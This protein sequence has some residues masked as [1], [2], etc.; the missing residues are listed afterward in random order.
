[1]FKIKI[2]NDKANLKRDSKVKKIIL[3]ILSILF[4][5]NASSKGTVLSSDS[6]KATI[7]RSSIYF[8][9]GGSGGIYSLN[10][11]AIFFIKQRFKASVRVGFSVYPE[12]FLWGYPEAVF[13]VM[14]QALYGEKNH[15]ELG[16]GLSIT[17]DKDRLNDDK[18]EISNVGYYSLGYRFQKPNGGF[19][20]GII[21]GMIPFYKPF[22][23]EPRLG[24]S[25]G[26]TIKTKQNKSYR[27]DVYDK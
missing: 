20:F 1:M 4:F 10:Y 24:V 3:L 13:P 11:D 16:A 27:D 12:K 23:I 18:T 7:C 21:F 5:I 25:L 19:M 22:E 2:E 9:A 14:I 26:Y 17:L 15:I 6:L 8:E